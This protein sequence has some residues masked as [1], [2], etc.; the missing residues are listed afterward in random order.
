[1]PDQ[2]ILGRVG[3]GFPL[4]QALLLISRYCHHCQPEISISP[5]MGAA[6]L[7][8]TRFLRR[9]ATQ[10]ALFRFFTKLWKT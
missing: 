8:A 7:S 4:V 6:T 9:Q 2:R 3:G 5:S 1:M 10:E